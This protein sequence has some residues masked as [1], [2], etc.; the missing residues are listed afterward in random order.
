MKFSIGDIVLLKRTGE[1]GR[2]VSLVNNEMIEV[3]VGGTHF[4]VFLDEVDHPYLKWF[5]EKRKNKPAAPTYID[6]VPVEKK[7]RGLGHG[8]ASGFHLSFLP[9]FRF[10]EFEDVVD[11][12]KAYF[13]NQTPYQLSLQYECS[14]QS[15]SIFSHKTELQPFSHFYLHDIPFD[16]MHDQ[17]RFSWII[18][19]KHVK[20][21]ADIL[22]DTLRIKPKKLFEYINKIQQDNNPMFHIKLADD[23]PVPE[24]AVF[25]KKVIRK[26]T[27]NTL[28][29][30]LKTEKKEKPRAEIDLHIEQLV[31][32]TT[33][34]S[35]FEML[36]VQL[37]AFEDALREAIN[38]HQQS[39]VVIHG[40]GKGRL[41]EEI[42]NMRR[43]VA[44]VDFFLADWNPRYGYGATE[45]F[46]RH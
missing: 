6:D 18:E 30:A 7:S 21:K 3:E 5:T 31:D 8:V 40:V 1:E 12:L 19:Q 34:L 32:D 26:E 28:V 20:A 13:I 16:E 15:G 4:P 11:K 25:E 44:E 38:N 2:V 17:P 41:K 42:H 22:S 23:F 36:T 29:T 9:V 27:V 33:G 24:D 10:D 43:S 45:I 46:F 14:S 37:E 35:N 39:L